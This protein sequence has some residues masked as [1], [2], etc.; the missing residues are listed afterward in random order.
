[1]TGVAVGVEAI[2]DR[3]RD[4]VARSTPLRIVGRGT[5]LDAGRPV[6]ASETL[7]VREYSGITEYV[8]G[9]LVLTA[10]AGTTLGEIR[11]ATAVHGQ[12]LAL[13]PYGSNEGTIGATIAT[14]AAGPLSTFFGRARDLVLGVEFITGDSVV[15]RGGGRVV[16][17]V[18]GFDLTRLITGSWGTLGVVTEVTMRLHARPE[19]DETIAIPLPATDGVERARRLLRQLPFAPFS[20]E[21]LNEALAQ[22]FVGKSETTALV[23]MGGN[24]ESVRAQHAAFA[25]L[26]DA[27][28]VDQTVWDTLRGIEP[29]GAIVFRLSRAPTHIGQVWSEAA[30]I[31]AKCP[32]AML[33]ANPVRGVVRCVLPADVASKLAP[34][35]AAPTE[36]IRVGERLPMELWSN[37]SPM[38][39][40][41][42]LAARIKRTFDPTGVLNPGI[43]GGNS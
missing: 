20:F 31:A 9:D 32:G 29:E 39:D 40:V 37:V 16:K 43:L 1:M 25:E 42:D 6:T 34:L 8:P 33:H 18:A 2:R 21:I 35:F 28:D 13:N 3:L 4:A 24:R 30:A 15:A 5:W 26:G 22:Q 10:R 12:W 14:G 23:R 17:N 27:R 11:E 38:P 7:S 19:A 41:G 36:T